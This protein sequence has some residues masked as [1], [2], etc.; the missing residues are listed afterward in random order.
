MAR[1]ETNKR[2]DHSIAEESSNLIVVF[3]R[4]DALWKSELVEINGT[5]HFQSAIVMG[6]ELSAIWLLSKNNLKLSGGSAFHAQNYIK[7][8]ET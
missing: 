1:N 7:A 8:S 2:N 6:N 4:V 5:K 3:E